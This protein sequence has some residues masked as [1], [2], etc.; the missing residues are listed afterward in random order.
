M[1]MDASK[2]LMEKAKHTLKRAL[3]KNGCRQQDSIRKTLQDFFYHQ[4]RSRPVI[5]PHVVRV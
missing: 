5:L 2:G 4:T 3:K 1:P